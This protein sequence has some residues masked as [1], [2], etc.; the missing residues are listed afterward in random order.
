M[1][2]VEDAVVE[3]LSGNGGVAALVGAHVFGVHWPQ[4][5]PSPAILVQLVSDVGG[6]HLR[7]QDA[8]STVRLQIDVLV[9]EDGTDAK[10]TANTVMAA[11]DGALLNQGPF[12][13]G[14]SPPT[15]RL[16]IVAQLDRRVFWE[17]GEFR[18][19]TVQ[20]DYQIAT[21]PI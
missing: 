13:A 7:G 5:P 17:A 18:T 3:I 6:A 10:T 12:H 1:A 16:A 8:L 19:V 14:G 21:A 4:K 20:Q 11:V 9:A 15:R 2:A